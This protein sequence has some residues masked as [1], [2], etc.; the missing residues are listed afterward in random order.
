MSDKL[1]EL[2]NVLH[3]SQDRMVLQQTIA[4]LGEIG[5]RQEEAINALIDIVRLT[6]DEPTRWV[7]IESLSKIAANHLKAIDTLIDLLPTSRPPTAHIIARYLPSMIGDNSSAASSLA[8]VARISEDEAILRAV[9]DI[10]GQIR[11]SASDKIEG[12]IYLAYNSSNKTTL[13][14]VI[15]SLKQLKADS[16]NAILAYLY[17]MRHYYLRNYAIDALSV[18]TLDPKVSQTLSQLKE[19]YIL[20]IATI[21]IRILWAVVSNLSILIGVPARIVEGVPKPAMKVTAVFRQFMGGSANQIKALKKTLNN[22]Q[23]PLECYLIARRLARLN[24]ATTDVVKSVLKHLQQEQPPAFRTLGYDSIASMSRNNP[25]CISL[26]IKSLSKTQDVEERQG[27]IMALGQVEK[28][29]SLVI[30]TLTNIISSSSDPLTCRLAIRSLKSVEDCD[31]LT[32][33]Y[34]LENLAKN[35][36]DPEMRQLIESLKY[37]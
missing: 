30:E 13:V 32:V 11:S 21:P 7:A 26:L 24:L 23:N 4:Q 37:S 2:I 5:T 35:H 31:F 14:R 19:S 6:S 33:S 12:L 36:P 22:T 17:L 16:P 3:S 20:A 28:K 9:T 25:S 18:V 1:Q 29:H 27:I 8:N 15:D 10:L 34:S